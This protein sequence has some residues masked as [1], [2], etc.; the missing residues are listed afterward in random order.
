MVDHQVWVSVFIA[1]LAKTWYFTFAG[2][3]VN[4]AYIN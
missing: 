4:F 2:R 3:L 1:K